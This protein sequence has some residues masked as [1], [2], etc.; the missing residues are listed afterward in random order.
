MRKPKDKGPLGVFRLDF[1]YS[2]GSCVNIVMVKDYLA[3]EDK[4]YKIIDTELITELREY[5][6]PE[7]E[8]K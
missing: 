5:F 8:E 7:Q 6:Y 3:T 1:V 4:A 2:D